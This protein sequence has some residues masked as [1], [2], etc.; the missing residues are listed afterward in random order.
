[1]FSKALFPIDMSEPIDELKEIIELMDNLT[2][3]EIFYFHNLKSEPEKSPKRKKQF[4][5]LVKQINKKFN[6]QLIFSNGHASSEITNFL[7]SGE[8]DCVII[9]WRKKFLITRTLLG[10]T[11]KDVVRLSKKPVIVYKKRQEKI[12]GSK[13]ILCAIDSFF[14]AKRIIPYLEELSTYYNDLILVDLGEREADP[15]SEEDRKK[16][17]FLKLDQ[18]ENG[19]A[20][21]FNSINKTFFVGNHSK[22]VLS[23]AKKENVEMIVINEIFENTLKKMLGPTPEE[24]CD[25]SICPV[26][27]I[28]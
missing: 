1:M 7:N 22:K 4:D 21:N 28:Q 2:V 15:Y 13:K 10:S 11:T 19:L 16:E 8:S 26:L 17:I 27:L 12:K 20:K 5:H 3:K 24:I 6:Y 9:P 23:L 14:P 25:K 18:I